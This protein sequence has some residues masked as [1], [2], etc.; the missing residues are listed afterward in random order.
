MN[1]KKTNNEKNILNNSKFHSTKIL[2]SIFTIL[3]LSLIIFAGPAKAFVLGLDTDKDTLTKG[4]EIT[5]TASLDIEAMDK[6]LPIKEL[7][8]FF[9]DDEVCKFDVDGDIISGCDGMTITPISVLSNN[10]KGYGYGYGYDNSYGYGYGYDFG[11][12]Y[13]YGYGYGTGG[14]EV[15][16]AYKIILDTTNY[17]TGD[18]V[19]QLKTLIGDKIFESKDKPIFTINAIVTDDTDD[20]ENDG[21]DEDEGEEAD[22]DE[23]ITLPN[24]EEDELID[25][26]EDEEEDDKEQ[27][28]FSKI[29][30][31]VIGAL[32]GPVGTTVVIVLLT[33]IIGVAIGIR[34]IRKGKLKIGRSRILGLFF[35]IGLVVINNIVLL[36]SLSNDFL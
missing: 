18:Y 17:E 8:L 2:A 20:G 5:F 23:T 15:H 9:N 1:N 28:L 27:G 19:S 24:Y 33:G 21:D 25:L 32:R 7:Y 30:G 35:L 31:A 4:G 13:G 12:G 10:D 36:F 14:S 11:Y 26:I 22:E 34:I 16:L 3:I 29:T 6:Y